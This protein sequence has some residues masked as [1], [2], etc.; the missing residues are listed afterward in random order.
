MEEIP[1]LEVTL[2]REAVK[3]TRSWLCPM[4]LSSPAPR[5][6]MDPACGHRAV[7]VSLGTG[8]TGNPILTGS[9]IVLKPV[10]HLTGLCACNVKHRVF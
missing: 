7:Q 4:S 5:N 1:S 3:K 8:C 10:L 6:P 2:K 9:K